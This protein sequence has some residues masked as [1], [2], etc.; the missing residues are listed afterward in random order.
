VLS[1][2]SL[3]SLVLFKQPFPRFNIFR[4]LVP[5]AGSLKVDFT[6]RDQF[7]STHDFSVY[8]SNLPMWC[9]GKHGIQPTVWPK[10]AARSRSD[11]SG[12]N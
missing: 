6:F 8:G 2:F 11:E 4:V 5:C 9:K 7:P 12:G 3:Q 10:R 1:V